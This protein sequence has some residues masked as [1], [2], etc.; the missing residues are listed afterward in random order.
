MAASPNTILIG[1]AKSGTTSL[2]ND[3]ARHGDIWILPEK[4]AHFFSFE[5]GRGIE[6]YRGLFRPDGQ[7]VVMEGS[8][9]Y[10]SIGRSAEIVERMMTHLPELKL[11]FMVRHPLERIESHYVQMISNG[12]PAIPFSQALADWPIVDGS[13][14]DKNLAI[15][16]ER[17]GAENIHVIFFEDY[18]RDRRGVLETLCTF[19]DIAFD[20][21]M[22]AAQGAKNSREE[23]YH[24]TRLLQRLRHNGAFRAL[25]RAMPKSLIRSLKSLILRRVTVEPDWTERDRE[26]TAQILSADMERFL[27][28][29]GKPADYWQL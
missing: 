3:L 10:A 1:A 22:V 14:Y 19:L 25:K 8:P 29:F 17:Y 15:F 26:R 20:E 4:E 6:W 21:D 2:C 13:L 18:K 16:A 28:R 24:D 11:I 7:S 9:E 23:K 5:Y 27:T 12:H